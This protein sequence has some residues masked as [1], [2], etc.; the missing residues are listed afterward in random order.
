M[1]DPLQVKP[2]NLGG[3]PYGVKGII[4]RGGRGDRNIWGSKGYVSEMGGGPEGKIPGTNP[5]P[6]MVLVSIRPAL[7]QPKGTTFI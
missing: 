6:E 4:Y 5:V 1:G 3:A 2:Y 7:P